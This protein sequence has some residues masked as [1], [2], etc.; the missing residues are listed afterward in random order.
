MTLV[1]VAGSHAEC[2]VLVEGEISVVR[3]MRSSP[4]LEP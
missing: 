3:T 4:E 1:H 2:L